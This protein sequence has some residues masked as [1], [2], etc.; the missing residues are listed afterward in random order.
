MKLAVGRQPAFCLTEYNFNNY[1]FHYSFF[2]CIFAG[3]K[4]LLLLSILLSALSAFAQKQKIGDFI[5][6]TSYNLDKIGVERQ[7]QYLPRP[8]SFVCENGTNRYTRALYGSYTDWRLETSDRPVFAVVKKDHH[9]N[10]R[11]VLEKDGVAYPLDETEYCRASY[12][13][14][15]R[16]YLLKDKRWGAGVLRIEVLAMPDCEAA[17]WRIASP[18]FEGCLRA[19]VCQIAQ[20][21]LHRN[22][23]IGAKSEWTCANTSPPSSKGQRS[24]TTMSIKIRT[25]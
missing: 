16:E 5:E 23:D 7:Q 15:R 2:C 14:G 18:Q 4:R 3:M 12:R 24:Y 1:K 13:D 10:I 19:I 8:G 21:K 20:P 17:V 25:F 22:G 6:S 9:R 11:F